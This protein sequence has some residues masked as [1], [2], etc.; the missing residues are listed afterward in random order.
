MHNA[1]ESDQQDD[2]ELK[3]TDLSP[4]ETR[5]TSSGLV[6]LGLRFLSRVR[7]PNVKVSWQAR[8]DGQ[9]EYVESFSDLRVSDLP[10]DERGQ[11]HGPPVGEGRQRSAVTLGPTSATARP[12]R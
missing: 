2:F 3:L 5:S 12:D 11:L 6:D 9:E 1:E 8:D 7:S 4:E 10:P